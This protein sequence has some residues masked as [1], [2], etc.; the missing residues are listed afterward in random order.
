MPDDT[1]PVRAGVGAPESGDFAS[2]PDPL[3]GLN[4]LAGPVRDE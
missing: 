2:T 4:R 3:A 1:P